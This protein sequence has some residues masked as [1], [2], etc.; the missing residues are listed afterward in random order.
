MKQRKSKKQRKPK[1]PAGPFHTDTSLG[2]TRLSWQPEDDQVARDMAERRRRTI[3][4]ELVPILPADAGS[5]EAKGGSTKLTIERRLSEQPADIRDA[6]HALSQEL[7]S[8][9]KELK[10][11]R[12]NDPDRI[13]QRDNLLVLAENMATGLANLADNLD[14]AISKGSKSKPE[15]AFLGKAANV[16]QQLHFGLMEWLEENRKAV[17]DVPY[18]KVGVFLIGV[19]FL[20]SLG[21]DSATAIGALGLLVKSTASKKNKKKRQRK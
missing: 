13:A 6:A 11:L 12:W 7:R 16:V 2:A 4:T 20:H 9:A 3:A 10:Q 18:L 8:Q 19:A 1:A 15:L 14:Q 21:A 17:F 5:Y